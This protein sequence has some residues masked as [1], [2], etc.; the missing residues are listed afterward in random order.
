MSEEAAGF[1]DMSGGNPDLWDE[2]G[3]AEFGE[4][5]GVVLVGLDTGFV[6]PG[7][8]AGVGDLDAGDESNDAI[9]EIP[10]VGGGFDGDDVGREE[11]VASPRGPL[12]EGDFEGFENDL[13]ERIDGGD[14]EEVFMQINAEK[15]KKA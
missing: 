6:D 4:L 5:D 13:L 10:G 7:E 1:A 9:V 12:I 8:S 11:M 14:E 3:G 15:T 2:A